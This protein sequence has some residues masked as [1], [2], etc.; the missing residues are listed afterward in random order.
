ME[1]VVE[2]HTAPL[3]Q[4]V[5]FLVSAL[6]AALG[7][8]RL[9]WSPVVGY[10][11]AGAVIGPHALGLVQDSPTIHLLSE[12]G[13]VFLMF[14]IGLELSLERL[15]SM[16]RYVFGLGALQVALSGLAIALAA[17]ALGLDGTEA[18]VIGLALAL[19][20][21]A[22]VMRLMMDQENLGSRVGRRAMGVLLFQDIAVVPI[23][24]LIG[25]MAEPAA[26][27]ISQSALVAAGQAL[28]ALVM[29]IIAGRYLGRPLFRIVA[30]AQSS[31]LF[32]AFTLLVV[33][34]A[35]WL[36]ESVG[37]SMAMGGFIAGVL[38]AETEYSAQ[39]Q[40]DIAPFRSLLLGLFFIGVGMAIDPT[41]VLDSLHYVLAILLG[42]LLLKAALLVALGRLSGLKRGELAHFGVLLAQGGEFAFVVFASAGTHDLLPQAVEQVL[43]IVVGLSIALTPALAVAGRR[44]EQRWQRRDLPGTDRLDTTGGELEGHVVIAGY[45]RVGR[46][47][48]RLLSDQGLAFI[49]LDMNSYNIA[50]A[51]ADGHPVFYGNAGNPETLKATGIKR[52]S[53]LVVTLDTPSAASRTVESARRLN[54]DIPV[55]VRAA[56]LRHG[57]ELQRLG[58]TAAVPETLEASL[59]LGGRTLRALGLSHTICDEILERVRTRDYAAFSEIAQQVAEDATDKRK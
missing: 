40:L 35:A 23:L 25:L 51:S 32:S 34:S 4:V 6:L 50:R 52:A 8:Q 37:L 58:A 41:V 31:E 36:M 5:I 17:M 7:V 12:F 42:L 2:S 13:I 15:R 1:A 54:P 30:S 16:W 44:L 19:S 14:T 11:I 10:L 38:L 55:I 56:D 26:R 48:A 45:G 18:T 33:L 9:R 57:E 46:T 27:S 39:V 53:A 29:V 59:Q 20:S 22:V 21:T 24:L 28:L 3:A 47:I 43:I 49:A